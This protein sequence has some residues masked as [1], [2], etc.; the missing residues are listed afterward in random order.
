MDGFDFQRGVCEDPFSR[1]ERVF[2]DILEKEIQE[3]IN[4]LLENTAVYC[5]KS[6]KSASGQC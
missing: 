5:R 3:Q 1:S 6:F 4:L 2:V